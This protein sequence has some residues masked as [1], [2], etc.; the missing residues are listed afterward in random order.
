MVDLICPPKLQTGDTIAIVAPS[1][2][3][4]KEDVAKTKIY[5]ESMGYKP[6]LGK[7]LFYKIGDYTAGT[8]EDRVEDLNWAFS[9][10]EV[11]AILMGQGG[12]A[13]DQVLD[14]LD[15]EK[16]AKNP[17]IFLGYSDATIL[18]MAFLAKA[19]LISF[20][21]TN[22]AGLHEMTDYTSRNLWPLLNGQK[23][24]KI[25]SFSKWE[26]LRVGKGKG[27]LIGGNLDSLTSVLGTRYDAFEKLKDSRIILFWEEFR[28]TFNIIIRDLFQ[29][30]HAGVFDRC[31]GMLVGKISECDENAGYSEEE[32]YVGVPELRYVLLQMAREFD[33]PI[34]YNVDFGHEPNKI[35][36]PQG[37]EGEIDT[38]TQTFRFN[39]CLQ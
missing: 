33:F 21:G 3:V 26:V 16:I 23:I 39:N 28:Q 17:K 35:T 4:E 24:E 15:Y 2:P 38:K 5:L 37:M 14:L 10:P 8:I 27:T 13:A 19:N 22:A 11:K 32:G 12:Y 34:L 20:H 1:E 30:K 25:E 18:Q 9:D 6:K 31:E 29:M 36:I 7:H